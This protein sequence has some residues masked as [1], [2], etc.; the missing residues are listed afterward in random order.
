MLHTASL[1]LIVGIVDFA[2]QAALTRNSQAKNKSLPNG[3]ASVL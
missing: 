3:T 1:Q 2:C